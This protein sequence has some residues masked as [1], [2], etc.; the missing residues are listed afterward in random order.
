MKESY[1]WS[2][3]EKSLRKSRTAR[4]VAGAALTLALLPAAAFGSPN[5]QP[6]KVKSP[7]AKMADRLE[8][9]IARHP[10]AK[11]SYDATHDLYWGK[12][13]KGIFRYKTEVPLKARVGAQ[14][15][16]RYFG[17]RNEGNDRRSLDVFPIPANAMKA[18]S[19]YDGFFHD[20]TNPSS[21]GT[22]QLDPQTHQATT[23]LTYAN[24]D[25]SVRVNVG[26]TSFY[27]REGVLIP[28][29][30]APVPPVN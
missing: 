27:G 15:I 13:D 29:P 10:D 9:K 11:V 19:Q 20:G 12:T 2:R 23:L 7:A 4:A 8:S 5:R 6:L 30:P 26:D 28:P 1:K 16:L 25:P 17:I 24:G 21:R 14:H 18:E 3:V 22:L